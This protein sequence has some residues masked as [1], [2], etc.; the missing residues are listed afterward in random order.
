MASL[1]TQSLLA[2]IAVAD[3]R[4]F[5]K[6]AEQL[7]LTQ[8]AVSKRIALLESQLGA[9]LFD[10]I[11]R[12]V[13]LTEAGNTLLPHAR[14]IVH[15]LDK[16]RKAIDDLGGRVSGRL[17]IA[18]SHHIGLHRLPPVLKRFAGEFPEVNF[19]IRFVDSEQAYALVERGEIDI[20]AVTLAP[21]PLDGIT[22]TPVWRDPLAFVCSPDHSLHLQDRVSLEQLAK[23]EAI[24]PGDN[25]YTGRIVSEAFAAR[26]LGLLCSMRTNYLETIKMIVSVGLGW[27]VLP[28]TMTESLELIDVEDIYLER[29]LGLIQLGERQLSNA[30]SAFKA[31][32]LASPQL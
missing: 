30:A 14:E 15:S 32:L 22:T 27:S 28:R 17:A 29:R 2:F 11:R 6:A 20:A 10:R 5:S 9:T 25:T 1:D 12:Q 8:P 18:F 24:L 19:D 3:N 31:M 7:H 4:S 26:D 16:A 13:L 21:E 23:L